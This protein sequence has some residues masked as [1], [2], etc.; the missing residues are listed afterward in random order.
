MALWQAVLAQRRAFRR[1]PAERLNL[2][3]Y[4]EA[5]G[6]PADS[7]Y[8]VEAAVL[9]NY[10]FDRARHLVPASTFASADLTHWL[11]LDVATEALA[12]AGLPGGG[13]HCGRT[14][15]VVGN[16][17]TGEFSRAGTLRYRWPY[18]RRQLEATL[19]EEGFDEARRDSLLSSFETRY[20]APFPAPDE[21]SLAGG[22]AN[23][24]AGRIAN[25][26]DLRG[27]GYTVDGACAS[28]LLAVA[29]A[30]RRLASGEVDLVLAG[31]VDLSLDPFE[32]VGFARNGA[33]SKRGMRVFDRHSDGFWPG[34]GCGFVALMRADQARA[35]GRTVRAVIR[36]WGVSS[37]GQGGLTR[38]TEAG[39]AQALERAYAA[40]GFDAGTVPLFEAHGT[41]TAVGDPIEIAAIAAVRRA[42]GAKFPAAIGSIKANIGHTKAAAG[43]AGLIK[44]VMALDHQIIPAVTACDDPHP[45]LQ[46]HA[47]LV[48]APQ[49]SRPWPE[50]LP[51][52]AGVSAFGFGGINVHL[53]LEAEEGS[54]RRGSDGAAQRQMRSAQDAELFVFAAMDRAA[55]RSGIA[56]FA[57]QAASLSG[58]EMVDSAAVLARRCDTGPERAMV[59]AANPAELARRLGLLLDRLDETTD[60]VLDPAEGIG[61]GRG[62]APRILFLFPGQAAPANLSGGAWRRRFETVAELYREEGCSETADGIGTQVAQPAITLAARAGLA[63]LEALGLQGAGAIGHSL[64]ELGALHWAGAYDGPA[65]QRIAAGRGRA[66]AECCLDGGT[67]LA[68]FA[69]AD[70]TAALIAGHDAVIACYNGPN[71][72]VIAGARQ[73][74]EAIEA[75][76]RSRGV[77]VQPLGVSHAFHSRF[78]APAAAAVSALV[79]REPIGSLLRPVYSTVEGRRLGPQDDLHALLGRQVEA[80]VRFAEA[81]AEASAGADLAIEVGPGQGLTRLAS[82]IGGP[83]V[84]A[85]DAGGDSLTGLLLA[86]GSAFVLGAPVAPSALFEDRFTR[87]FDLERPRRFLANPCESAPVSDAEEPTRRP[88]V[89]HGRHRDMSGLVQAEGV[90]AS[91]GV[92]VKAATPLD[93]LRGLLA[94]RLDLAEDA[95][96]PEHR[97]FADL[98]LNSIAVGQIVGQAARALGISPPSSPTNYALATVEEAAAALA[99]GTQISETPATDLLAGVDSWVRPFAPRELPRPLIA[100]EIRSNWH[101]RVIAPEGHPLA[102]VF[103]ESSSETGLAAVALCL[104]EAPDFDHLPLILEA[105]QA[106]QEMDSDALLLVVQCGGGGGASARCL[107]LE[108]PGLRVVVVDLAFDDSRAGDWLLDEA[109]AARPGYSECRYDADGARFV[110]SLELLHAFEPVPPDAMPGPDDVWLVS[111]GG[112]G[113]GAECALAAARH[114][115]VRIAIVGRSPAT[116]DAVRATMKRFEAAG[117]EVAYESADVRD[118]AAVAGAVDR[119]VARLGLVTGLIHAAGINRP[120]PLAGLDLSV[121]QDTVAVKVRGFRNLIA[122]LDPARLKLAVGFSSIIARLGLPGE[123]HYAVANE[124]LGRELDSF[125]ARHT[126]CRCLALE[127]SVWSGVG[128]GERLGA[129]EGLGRL[130]VA[131]VPTALG[132]AIFEDLIAC[133]PQSTAVVVAGRFG[134]PGTIALPRS[135]RPEGRF[136]ERVV[137][138]YPGVEIVAECR[139]DPVSDPYLI[140]HALGDVP[141]FPAVLGLEA[142]VQAAA[143]LADGALPESLEAVAFRRP[144]VAGGEGCT[145]R[146]AALVRAPDRIETVL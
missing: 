22:L 49:E 126:H 40:A 63:V 8:P 84:I 4:D 1:M 102:G 142:M 108:Y 46:E 92:P 85:L 11:A 20:K 42:A 25:H 90:A 107:S 87:D 115:G 21:E 70:R 30:C 112:S 54:R 78:A 65:L 13:A 146:I 19:A 60:V 55:L 12:D 99:K 2:A 125:A 119:L 5:H 14:G 57:E 17:L 100:R 48:T 145:L 16:S 109:A 29:S 80:P 43:L 138:D 27:G 9:E 136:L 129:V 111:G 64:G 120:Q 137:V 32:L 97:L 82:A 127:W 96:R 24:I 88:A 95:I 123:T 86:A 133:L 72:C 58:A 15:V 89:S 35:E 67:M 93:T 50:D 47:A 143:V 39:Q 117:V 106:V 23:T 101:W 56:G 110:P 53:A 38:P 81:W 134:T 75:H 114:S 44:Q 45:V 128:M 77:G 144:V 10:V 121:L 94:Q 26:H 7:I 59:L 52:R 36:G 83:P 91:S 33:L 68:V 3:D 71:D 103:R 18:V 135:G 73:D 6:D 66:M 104:P 51:L 74:I 79:E 28:S 76:A 116:S 105:G 122:A 37:D 69:P 139:L 118:A 140:E 132:T 113:I 131:A 34:E 31:G 41:G 61:F 124:W 141:L 98:H 130:G 62:E